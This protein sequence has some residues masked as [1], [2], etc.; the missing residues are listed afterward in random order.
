MESTNITAIFQQLTIC[1]L[2]AAGVKRSAGWTVNDC[3]L[4]SQILWAVTALG[5][6]AVAPR[7]SHARTVRGATTAITA[8]WANDGEDKVT[9]DELRASSGQTVTNSLWNGTTITLFGARN[10]VINFNLILEAATATAKNV[11]VTLSNLNGPKG[12][13]IRYAPR[14]AKDL[15]NWTSTESELFYVRYLQILGLSNYGYGTLATWQEATFPQRAQCPTGTGCAWIDRPVANKYYPDIAV[16]IELIPT[17]TIA[18]AN[19]QSIWADI[20]IPKTVATGVYAGTISIRENG[21][22]TYILPISLKVRKFTLPDG[23]S[24][25]TMLFTS[26][27]DLSPRYGNATVQALQNQMLVAHRHKISL[28]DD[29]FGQGFGTLQPTSQWVPYLT[30]SGFTSSNGYAGPGVGIGQDVFSIGTYGTMTE[31]G[32]ETRKLFTDQFNGWEGWFEANSPST[33]RF[34]YLCDEIDCQIVKPSLKTQLQWWSSITGVGKNLHTMATQVLVTAP[35]ELS[36]PT[37]TWPFSQG[38]WNGRR[39][40]NG[41]TIRD[42]AAAD[43]VLKQEP[44]RRLF[45]YNGDRPGAGSMETE[46]DGTSLRELAW[47]QYKKQ[48]DRWFIWESTYYDSYQAG[49]PG[50]TDLFTTAQTFGML[51]GNRK[52]KCSD[53]IYGRISCTSANGNGVLIYPGTD[54]VFPNSSYGISGP[55]ASLRLKHW[56]RGIQD[57]DYLTLAAAINPADVANL[58]NQMVPSVLW[59]QQCVNPKNDCTYTYSPIAW[60]NTPDDWESARAQLAHIIDGQ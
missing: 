44:A 28:I 12:S 37:S 22:V 4:R 57:V 43:A 29:N 16:P 10:E 54:N 18:A 32:S 8:V 39:W 2:P 11:S 30:G 60:S 41:Y 35:T 5:L 33:E 9:Q 42:Q 49:G 50:N 15:F 23:P 21:N 47:G 46:D 45:A 20:Y 52:N 59:E 3:H 34:V 26:Y 40:V 6:L 1:A 55:I 53:P 14:P 56:R 19:N 24:S 38:N 51:P 17:F 27:S 58:V 31:G 13:V 7:D 25:K 48:I 36:D